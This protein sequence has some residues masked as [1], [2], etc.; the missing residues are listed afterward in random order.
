MKD[1]T[2]ILFGLC[3]CSCHVS[4]ES[5]INQCM[6]HQIE[7]FDVQRKEDQ[8]VFYCALDQ[9]SK[10]M[11][12]FPD[13]KDLGTTGVLGFLIS[14]LKRPFHLFLLCWIIVLYL[15]LSHTLFRIDFTSTSAVLQTEIELYLSEQKIVPY[16]MIWDADFDD[17]LK[18][19]IKMKFLHQIAWIEVKRNASVLTVSFNHK[20]SK[21]VKSFQSEPLI[22]TKHAIV[23]SFDLLHG[24]KTVNINQVVYPGDVLVQPYLI[25]SKGVYKPI[26]VSGKVMGVTWYT[27]VSEL[28]NSSEIEVLDF[29]R[30]LMNARRQI[31]TEIS[32]D[33]QVLKENILQVLSNEGKI[34]MTVHYTC[35]EDITKQ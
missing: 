22:S 2:R 3:R 34:R 29:L 6:I 4:L 28:E 24:Y 30:L 15:V 11:K 20:D 10:L 17:Q 32:E 1:K 23:K 5:L 12:L 13:V 19:D 26:F 35:L 21:E 27:I 8:T 7:L 25:D 31:E 33:E 16:A 9:K 14:E 18:Q